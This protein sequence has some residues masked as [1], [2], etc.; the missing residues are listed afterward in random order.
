MASVKEDREAVKKPSKYLDV[1]GKNYVPWTIRTERSLKDDDAWEYVIDVAEGGTDEPDPATAT[2]AQKKAWKEGNSKA[3][4]VIMNYLQDQT[5]TSVSTHKNSA[6]NMWNALEK[7]MTQSGDADKLNARTDLGAYQHK[8]SA[9]VVET[10]EGMEKLH[11]TFEHGTNPVPLTNVEKIGYL[12]TALACAGGRWITISD[13][14]NSSNQQGQHGVGYAPP[15][16]ESV[17]ERVEKEQRDKVNR[18]GAWMHEKVPF[19][20]G[21]GRPTGGYN[22]GN[23]TIA[24]GQGRAYIT[25]FKAAI[26]NGCTTDVADSIATVA[27]ANAADGSDS[28]GAGGGGAGGGY[29]TRVRGRCYKCGERGHRQADCKSN[30]HCGVCNKNNHWYNNCTRKNDNGGGNGGGDNGGG[31]GNGNTQQRGQRAGPVGGDAASHDDD[32]AG[33]IAS[34]ATARGLSAREASVLA[35]FVASRDVDRKSSVEIPFDSGCSQTMTDTSKHLSNYRRLSNHPGV[36]IA[37]DTVIPVKGVGDQKIVTT[38]KNGESHVVEIKNTLHVP[39]LGEPLISVSGMSDEGCRITFMENRGPAIVTKPTKSESKTEP[40]GKTVA[41]AEHN[42]TLWTFLANLNEL[43]KLTFNSALAFKVN[44][45]LWHKRFGHIGVQRLKILL[46]KQLARRYPPGSEILERRQKEVM[47]S[48]M[49][50]CEVCEISNAKKRAA[51]RKSSGTS[52]ATEDNER[53]YIDACIVNVVAKTGAVCFVSMVDCKTRYGFYK[54]L[55]ARRDIYETFIEWQAHAEREMDKPIRIIRC[56]NAPEYVAGR[57]GNHIRNVGIKHELTSVDTSW[58]NNVAERRIQTIQGMIRAMLVQ[59]NL[60]D[61]YWDWA[62]REANEMI[63]MTPTSSL[64]NNEC[65]YKARYGKEP[66]IDLVK[67]FGSPAYVYNVKQ[68]RD[69]KMSNRSDRGIQ[70][71]RSPNMF[72]WQVEMDK[73]GHI[74]NSTNVKHDESFA[75]GYMQGRIRRQATGLVFEQMGGAPISAAEMEPRLTV[76]VGGNDQSGPVIPKRY[77]QFSHHGLDDEHE[78]ERREQTDRN[79]SHARD[80]P[81]EEVQ[82]Q[83]INGV[84]TARDGEERSASRPTESPEPV[85]RS[86]RQPKPNPKYANLARALKAKIGDVALTVRTLEK[87]GMSLPQIAMTVIGKMDDGNGTA[88]TRNVRPIIE[89]IATIANVEPRTLI[90][91]EGYEEGERKL[92]RAA[93]QSEYDALMKN[94][95]WM[96]VPPERGRGKPVRCKWVF[97]AKTGADGE[98]TRRKAR[99]VAL[100]FSQRHGVDYDETWAPTM[101][102]VSMRTILGVATARGYQTR[103]ADVPNAYLKSTLEHKVFMRQPEGFEV[104]GKEDWE[105]LLLKALYGLKQAGME[106]HKNISKFF[107]DLGYV[108]CGMD[109][110][111]FI[112]KDNQGW[113][114]VV[115]IHVDDTLIVAR[116]DYEIEVLGKALK[117]K[118]NADVEDLTYYCGIKIERDL[119]SKRTFMSQEAYID[120]MVDKY[121]S[122]SERSVRNP[123]TDTKLTKE[124]CPQTEDEINKMKNVPYR[125]LVGALLYAAMMTRPDIAVAV[126]ELSKFMQN[127]GMDHWRAAIRV[128][129]YLKGTKKHGNLFDGTGVTF[130][131]KGDGTSQMGSPVHIYCDADYAGDL[132]DRRSMS[133]LMVSIAGCLVYWRAKKQGGVTLSTMESEIVSLGTAVQFNEYIVALLTELGIE[134]EMPSVIREDNQSAIAYTKNAK[135]QS[136]ARHIGVRFH[137]IRE[138]V[139][140]GKVRII[141]CPTDQM[142]ADIFTKRL[143]TDQFEYLRNGIGIVMVPDGMRDDKQM[144]AKIATIYG[145]WECREFRIE[146]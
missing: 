120:K 122:T 10:L 14:L 73:D 113:Q 70:V 62:G 139:R 132:D 126:H 102:P 41:V 66:D 105:C 71:G 123:M 117:D 59:A 116:D 23:K 37:D 144:I 121:D 2:N 38:T 82:E 118:Y 30:M 133:G 7:T 49:E 85:R 33:S 72:G 79:L 34:Y 52:R 138:S 4:A 80:A 74:E 24:K 96:L 12:A 16:Y 142:L 68:G 51:R 65:P 43:K 91:I 92:W 89:A 108:Q 101:S 19:Q 93:T 18:R 15:T 42:G 98:L 145:E 131:D 129:R 56:D 67:T 124:M 60:G 40:V 48:L 5:L 21:G 87:M 61:E 136:K 77:V 143:P 90:E 50:F 69:N 110:C 29:G 17:R 35:D 20:F 6:R 11:R 137:Y 109:N 130:T 141:Y 119:K 103:Q 53:F 81:D 94:Q 13:E 32:D 127:P 107:L 44:L 64:P 26:D 86:D 134:T 104:E 125:N 58:M 75:T 111:V 57:L 135:N 22:G 114:T 31:N 97:K 115:G 25:S 76:V 63:N 3:L 99:L 112:K 55:G 83:Q 36:R 8:Y 100:G 128:L 1:K 28:G 54:G 106:W 78:Q 39:G 88:K 146:R 46:C 140:D 27:Q 47:R 95:T 84:E 45:E 9:D